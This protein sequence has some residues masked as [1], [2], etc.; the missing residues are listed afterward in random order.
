MKPHQLTSNLNMV[1]PVEVAE[2]SARIPKSSRASS[3][4]EVAMVSP[5]L[6]TDLRTYPLYV[7]MIS[8]TLLKFR[9][10]QSM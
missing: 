6:K 2:F 7:K 3:A 9:M 10:F 1:E 8:G 4:S 5:G